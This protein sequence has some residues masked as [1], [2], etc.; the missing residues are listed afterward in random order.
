[1]RQE[2]E[3]SRLVARRFHG[4]REERSKKVGSAHAA[5]TGTAA[6]RRFYIRVW[7]FFTYFFLPSF[8]HFKGSNV[9][10]NLL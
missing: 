7:T 10:T 3:G 2:R 8:Q 9:L 1:M 4:K 6:H 5:M